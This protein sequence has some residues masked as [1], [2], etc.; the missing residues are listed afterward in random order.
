MLFREKCRCE[1]RSRALDLDD[2]VMDW[3]HMM[4]PSKVEL[5]VSA[6][7]VEFVVLH[8]WGE[9]PWSRAALKGLAEGARTE[10]H[11]SAEPSHSTPSGDHAA[12]TG[13]SRLAIGL[14]IQRKSFYAQQ[15]C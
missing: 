8:I 2:G 1:R 6:A 4:R 15:S 9:V 5:E 7:S 11:N 13:H 14:M 3:K 12:E 10:P